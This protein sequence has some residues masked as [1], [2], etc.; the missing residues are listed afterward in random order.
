MFFNN[1][2]LLMYVAVI[3]GIKRAKKTKEHTAVKI[4]YEKSTLPNT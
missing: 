1:E 4:F 3:K 2:E